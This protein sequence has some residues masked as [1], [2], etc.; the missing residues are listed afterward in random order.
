MRKVEARIQAGF[1]DGLPPHLL[2]DAAALEYVAG[3]DQSRI[4]VSSYSK[5]C[6]LEPKRIQAILRE[7]LILVHGHPFEYEYGW[8][9]P[10]LG[11]LFDVDME[12]SVLGKSP[13]SFVNQFDVNIIQCRRFSIPTSLSYGITGEASVTSTG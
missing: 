6:Q 11:R 4:F 8:D 3:T 7:R 13:F 2:P 12:V 5:F 9:L 10:S 1:R